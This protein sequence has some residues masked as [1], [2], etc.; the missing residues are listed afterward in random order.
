M[1]VQS[2]LSRGKKNSLQS[3]NRRDAR[4]KIKICARNF[5]RFLVGFEIDGKIERYFLFLVL[6]RCVLKNCCIVSVLTNGYVS[7]EL[8]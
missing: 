6:N 3:E 1:G 8:N 4:L 7:N 2:G 5:R